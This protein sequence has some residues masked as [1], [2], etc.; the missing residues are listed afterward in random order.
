MSVEWFTIP[1]LAKRLGVH[2]TTVRGWVKLGRVPEP[3]LHPATGSQV[4]DEETAS[5][6]ERDYMDR[7]AE[8]GSRGPGA[9]ERVARAQAFQKDQARE[10]EPSEYADR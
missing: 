7:V 4:Y 10:E 8:E 1:D 6:I 5:A 3:P 9:K 2:A